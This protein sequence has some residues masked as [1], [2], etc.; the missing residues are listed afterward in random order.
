MN[1]RFAPGRL[2]AILS[3]AL[4]CACEIETKTGS[5]GTGS[6]P[7]KVEPS[8]A[9]GTLIGTEPF[10]LGFGSLDGTK[11]YVRQNES[12]NLGTDRYRLGMNFE[13]SGTVTGDL[14]SAPTALADISVQDAARGELLTI[15]RI[16][17]RFLVA[18]LT[19]VVDANTLYDGVAGFG[20]MSPGMYVEVYGLPTSDLRTL[21]ATRITRTSVDGRTAVAARIDP[22][23]TG[24]NIAGISIPGGTG[25]DFSPVPA[26]GG[27]RA[28]VSGA[29]N[30]LTGAII[31]E[32][33][34]L[35]PD[36]APS[37]GTRVEI[38]GIALDVAPA[39]GFRL[40]T[41]ARDYM[42]AAG[43]TPSVPI[44]TGSRVRVVGSASSGQLLVPESI[45]VVPPGQITYRV[46]GTVTE[47]T[48]LASL[49]VRGEPADLT[50]AVIR[51]GNAS[52]IANGKRLSIVGTAGPGALRVSEVTIVP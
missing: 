36:Y 9:A 21:L 32:R 1:E 44:V 18:T 43:A 14:G 12:V 17:Q 16:G 37:G 13:G 6:P 31:T 11:A 10:T 24:I 29:Y 22:A 25:I 46:T 49:R 26:G 27:T 5:N 51:G 39:G 50:L 28:R 38:E 8:V 34:F 15:D 30:A 48:S 52:D 41:S 40:R 33:V 19:F 42:V 23:A 35:L 4:L 45:T 7:P 47:F 20:A 2:A 3:L